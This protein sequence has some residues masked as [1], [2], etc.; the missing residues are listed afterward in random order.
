MA[1]AVSL[2]ANTTQAVTDLPSAAF[3]E[4]LIHA[5]PDAQVILT[6]RNVDDWYTS[7]CNT[8][9]VAYS[10]RIVSLLA[11]CGDPVL[12]RYLPMVNA[13]WSGFF[14]IPIKSPQFPCG[15]Q[16]LKARFVEHYQTVRDLVPKER[17]LER[18]IGEGWGRICQFL[19]KP[20]P[21]VSFP[22]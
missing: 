6:T 1:R 13:L 15:E 10:S 22:R 7:V 5:Y 11:M 4:E 17:L 21:A 8:I 19:D 12:S 18:E 20:I 16:V 14:R 2:I 3:V 9:G